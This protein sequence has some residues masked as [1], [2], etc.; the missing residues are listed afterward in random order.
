M[1][2]DTLTALRT[3]EVD[4]RTVGYAEYGAPDGVPALFLHGTP[5]CRLTRPLDDD[6]YARLGLRVLVVDRAGYGASDPIPGRRVVDSVADLLAVLEVEG[7]EKALVVGG[8]GGGPHALALAARAPERV[9]A[10]GV[11]VGAAPL[12]E[13]EVALQAATN[14]AVMAVVQDPAGLRALLG[15]LRETLLGAGLAALLPDVSEHDRAKLEA[16]AT[17]NEQVMRTA[18][19]DGV[20]GWADD[21]AALWGR[22]WGFEP[23]DVG[24]PVVWCHGDEDNMVPLP[25]AQRLASRLPSC[26]FVVWRGEGHL[27][28]AERTTELWTATLAR[29]LR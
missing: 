14:Q 17:R 6:L 1:T 22:P 4:G 19:A 10:V 15:R 25:A 18:L 13:S 29:A 2:V 23:E 27:L 9:L 16:T 28:S 7:V 11:A 5:G 26:R 24:V 12:E 20:E 3:T 8:S 21:Y